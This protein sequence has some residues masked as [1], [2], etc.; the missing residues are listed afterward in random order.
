[1]KSKIKVVKKYY[2]DV[3]YPCL[4]IYTPDFDFVVL[5]TSKNTGMV[6]HSITSVWAV[7]DYVD[8]WDEGYFT[9]CKDKVILQN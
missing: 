4:R 2:E 3:E 5:F 7:G 9:P 8:D 6:V 1:M